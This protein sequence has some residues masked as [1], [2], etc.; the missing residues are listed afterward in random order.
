MLR[1]SLRGGLVKAVETLMPLVRFLSRGP[2]QADSVKLR[3]QGLWFLNSPESWL[4]RN[5]IAIS[6]CFL[7]VAV[8]NTMSKSNLGIKRF[9]VLYI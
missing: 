4:H 2:I 1:H 8:I 9:T 5:D 7:S 6:F 3:E